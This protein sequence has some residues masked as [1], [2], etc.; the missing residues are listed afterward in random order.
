MSRGDWQNRNP[1][2]SAMKGYARLLRG[3]LTRLSEHEA[4]QGSGS[5]EKAVTGRTRRS[6]AMQD[7]ASEA[8]EQQR[9][10]IWAQAQ[11]WRDGY[12]H[13]EQARGSWREAAEL[14]ARGVR[15]GWPDVTVYRAP[16]MVALEL[17]SEQHRPKNPQ[18]P[19]WWLEWDVTNGWTWDS[20]KDPTRYGLRA[21][22]AKTLAMLDGC[23]Y[24]TCV[25]YGADE[26]IRWLQ[27]VLG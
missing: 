14:A 22:Q 11:P 10:T 2:K 16:L 27:G 9:L 4:M 5:G 15:P 13:H 25:A 1:S 19:E 6:K 17:K 18:P 21:S 23:G 3:S 8:V 7:F 20:V 26:A 24:R 12:V